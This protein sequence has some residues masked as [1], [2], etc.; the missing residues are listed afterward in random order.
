MQ[1]SAI[2]YGYMAQTT[3]LHSTERDALATMTFA[4]DNE[5]NQSPMGVLCSSPFGMSDVSPQL[6]HGNERI[7]AWQ[8]EVCRFNVLQRD[9]QTECCCEILGQRTKGWQTY[10]KSL[11]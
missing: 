9:I 1:N 11:G 6:L 10:E 4:L 2:A 5:K 8:N 3:N 7:H